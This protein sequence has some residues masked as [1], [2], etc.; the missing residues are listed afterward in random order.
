MRFV[1][2]LWKK[3][4]QKIYAI[5]LCKRLFKVG[6]VGSRLS[7][8]PVYYTLEQIKLSDEKYLSKQLLGRI[9]RP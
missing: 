9:A 3:V 2:I 1:Y 5:R 6:D 4:E 7:S 8:I